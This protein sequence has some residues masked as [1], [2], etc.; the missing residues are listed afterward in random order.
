MGMM[1]RPSTITRRAEAILALRGVKEVG[2]SK[3]SCSTRRSEH[4]NPAAPPL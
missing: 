1:A 2:P 4:R 3:S